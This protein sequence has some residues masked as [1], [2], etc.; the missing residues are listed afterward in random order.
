MY[1]N[2]DMILK[3]FN[4][5]KEITKIIYDYQDY[6]LGRNL[7]LACKSVV[8]KERPLKMF[9]NIRHESILRVGNVIELNEEIYLDVVMIQKIYLDGYFKI[10][11]QRISYTP[12]SP[13][14]LRIYSLLIHRIYHSDITE[15]E[16]FVDFGTRP[17]FN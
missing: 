8:Y 4:I 5:P 6:S 10:N 13:A 9:R 7:A 3:E 15:E 1:Y 12:L 16:L 11:C 2:F 14:G 17:R